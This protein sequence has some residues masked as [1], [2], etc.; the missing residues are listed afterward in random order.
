MFAAYNLRL[1][2]NILG[3]ETIKAYLEELAVLIFHIFG[4]NRL[5]KI[6]FKDLENLIEKLEIEILNV[7]M[8]FKTTQNFAI[9]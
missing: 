7:C 2:I 3:I 1:I 4:I 5:K 8:G 9:F 6:N